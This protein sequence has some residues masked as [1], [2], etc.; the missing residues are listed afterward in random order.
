MLHP[1]VLVSISATLYEIHGQII[2]HILLGLDCFC[3]PE[4]KTLDMTLF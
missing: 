1:S 3:N 4:L 2:L